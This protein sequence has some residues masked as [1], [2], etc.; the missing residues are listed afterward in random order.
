MSTFLLFDYHAY[1][2][3][4]GYKYFVVPN[5]AVWL[6]RSR[7]QIYVR[8][9]H[10]LEAAA[11][12]GKNQ[13]CTGHDLCCEYIYIVIRE[14]VRFLVRENVSFL[15]HGGVILPVKMSVVRVCVSVCVR[16]CVR[17]LYVTL[18]EIL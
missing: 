8:D 1:N 4:D 13:W 10:I 2:V 7:A 12:M 9:L 15:V 6:L 3:V 16:V 17:P 18:F 14:N 5:I 11:E